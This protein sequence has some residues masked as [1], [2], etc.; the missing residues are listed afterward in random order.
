MRFET[1]VSKYSSSGSL[2]LYK[3]KKETQ[4]MKPSVWS[5]TE[6]GAKDKVGSKKLAESSW[7]LARKRS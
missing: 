7:Q 3:T 1:N 6:R 2:T 4:K 5:E